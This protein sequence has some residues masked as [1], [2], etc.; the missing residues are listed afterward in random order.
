MPFMLEALFPD[1]HQPE[2]KAAE[3]DKQKK[4]K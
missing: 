4:V 2:N 3:H 1:S